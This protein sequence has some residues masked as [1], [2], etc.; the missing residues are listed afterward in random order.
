MRF[1]LLCLA[2]AACGS[3]AKPSPTPPKQ[4]ASARKAPPAK[5]Q[6]SSEEEAQSEEEAPPEEEDEEQKAPVP[7][8]FDP[9]PLASLANRGALKAY[10]LEKPVAK[11]E[12]L[13]PPSKQGDEV[14]IA[15]VC[16]PLGEASMEE[17]WEADTKSCAAPAAERT[18]PFA[19]MQLLGAAQGENCYLLAP[20]VEGGALY[21]TETTSKTPEELKKLSG[22]YKLA[23]VTR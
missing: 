1:L 11:L 12:K 8:P 15:C 4:V 6:V 17:G 21:L 10:R 23:L 19:S 3:S 2:L 22:K 7:E 5:E 20:V 16:W 13:C 9:P 18:A 14:E